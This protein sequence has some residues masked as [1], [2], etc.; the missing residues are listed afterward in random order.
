M[1]CVKA[2]SFWISG[3]VWSATRSSYTPIQR[4]C[5]TL[6]SS[7]RRSGYTKLQ[8]SK[9]A[10]RNLPESRKFSW[11]S[12]NISLDFNGFSSLLAYFTIFLQFCWPR[13][14]SPMAEFKLEIMH[15][16]QEARDVERQLQAVEMNHPARQSSRFGQSSLLKS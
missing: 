11:T 1:F 5:E 12:M 2:S 15:G 7:T 3:P 9:M 14:T 16:F 8:R 10:S 13:D 4:Y 6:S